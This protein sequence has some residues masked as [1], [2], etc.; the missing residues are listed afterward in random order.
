MKIV[1]ETPKWSFRK[2]EKTEDGFKLAF[3]SPI[4]TPFNYG[5]IEGTLGEDGAPL[6]VIVLGRRVDSWT[7]LNLGIIG[8]VDFIDDGKGDDKYI[9]TLDGKKHETAIL[10]FFTLYTV[11]KFFLGLILYRSWTTNRF[12]GVEWFGKEKEVL[13]LRNNDLNNS[14]VILVLLSV[15]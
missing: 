13:A 7:H 5:F 15:F 2:I 4:P 8:R 12:N 9:A 1:I 3:I 10:L 14:K 6:D 11:A